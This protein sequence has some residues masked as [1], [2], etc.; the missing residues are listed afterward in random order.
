MST[1][2]MYMSSH[3]KNDGHFHIIY[4]LFPSHVRIFDCVYTYFFNGTFVL[5]VC[6]RSTGKTGLLQ[7]VL[8]H[9]NAFCVVY[10]DASKNR[11]VAPAC[12]QI[13]NYFGVR[14]ESYV[15]WMW[16]S[17]T[18]VHKTTNLWNTTTTW[19]TTMKTSHRMRITN[20]LTGILSERL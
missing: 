12:H 11:V 19:T 5:L 14:H 17:R 15:T 7:L 1:Q 20:T 9:F 8:H 13:F 10:S 18:V 4:S 3:C 2:H 6:P 16:S